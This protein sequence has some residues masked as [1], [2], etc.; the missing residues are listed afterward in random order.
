[1]TKL[2]FD[3]M[4]STP[5]HPEVLAQM[6]EVYQNYPGNPSSDHSYGEILQNKI[7]LARHQIITATNAENYE[8]IWTSGATEAINLSIQGAA[9]AYKRQGK[10]LITFATEHKATLE[11]FKYLAEQGFVTSILP[12]AS[13]GLISLQALKAAITNTTILVSIC[14][15]NNEIGCIQD[16]KA[17]VT[18]IQAYGCLVHIDAAQSIGKVKLDLNSIPADFVSLSAHKFYGPQGAGALLVRN[19][20]KRQLMP[21][22][23]GGSQQPMRP[24]TIPAALIV[25]MGAAIKLASNYSTT[26]LKMHDKILKMLTKLGGVTIHGC[27]K[28]RVPHNLNIH[29]AG[30]D[31]ESLKLMLSNIALASG[32]ACNAKS[33]EPS[34]VLLALGYTKEHAAHALRI[35]IGPH[36]TDAMINSFCEQFYNSV[37]HL[38]RL[39]GY[40]A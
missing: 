6:H 15:V 22:L 35:S 12:V 1:M 8:I 23:Y 14:H 28:N 37:L 5:I 29:I 30:L 40:N 2:Y 16:L 27:Q 32:S 36:L 7:E 20:P 17:L 21:L 25:G 31:S 39:A 13:D 33:P 24:G 19:T 18:A 10:H 26:T 11:T 3:S 9:Q 4:A 38:R 34:H